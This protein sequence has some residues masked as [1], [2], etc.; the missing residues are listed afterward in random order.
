VN[1]SKR[2]LT[3]VVETIKSLEIPQDLRHSLC[4]K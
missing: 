4:H 3:A 1:S 2:T